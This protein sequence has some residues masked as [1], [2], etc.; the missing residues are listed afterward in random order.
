MLLLKGRTFPLLITSPLL[1]CAQGKPQPREPV[2]TP[3]TGT[4]AAGG[5][6]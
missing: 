6:S 1:F 2:I 3:G 5:H 4:A